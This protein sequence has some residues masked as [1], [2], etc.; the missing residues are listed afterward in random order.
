ML[1]FH[2]LARLA[3][4]DASE[5]WFLLVLTDLQTVGLTVPPI[6]STAPLP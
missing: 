6:T 3:Y 5:I 1:G 4:S 2:S